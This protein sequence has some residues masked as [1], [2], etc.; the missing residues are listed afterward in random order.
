MVVRML[1]MVP[2]ALLTVEMVL[3]LLLLLSRRIGTSGMLRE[4]KIYPIEPR[5]VKRRESTSGVVVVVEEEEAATRCDGVVETRKVGCGITRL[6]WARRCPD[7]I[8]RHE[9]QEPQAQYSTSLVRA[10]ATPASALH[11]P[12]PQARA[13]RAGAAVVLLPMLALLSTYNQVDVWGDRVS[14]HTQYQLVIGLYRSRTRFM[15]ADPSRRPRM[16]AGYG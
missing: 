1:L 5:K 15:D 14:C 2:V 11:V 9:A 10:D 6:S 16:G 8:P 4:Q 7:W 3:L 13:A 12:P